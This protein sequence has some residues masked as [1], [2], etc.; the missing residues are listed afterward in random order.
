MAGGFW[1]HWSS[2]AEI[3]LTGN[4]DFHFKVSANGSSWKESIIIDKDTGYVGVGTAPSQPL[5]IR[6]DASSTHYVKVESAQAQNAGFQFVCPATTWY[7]YNQNSTKQWRFYNGGTR[8]AI[9]HTGQIGI[10]TTTLTEKVNVAGN[11]APSSSGSYSLGTAAKLWSDVYATNGTINTSDA[12]LK[13]DIKSSDLGLN[14]ILGLKPIRYKWSKQEETIKQE[15]SDEDGV[16]KEVI[17]SKNKGRRTHY[18]LLAQDVKQTLQDC[19][20]EDF[21]G[22]TLADKDAPDSAQGLRY[23]ELIAPLIKA[24]QELNAKVKTLKS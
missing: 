8:L 4:D 16:Y 2:R 7:A 14:F 9:A 18:G 12:R 22:W 13:T 6:K 19:G 5:T 1:R 11:I 24:V 20:C 15:T 21:A 3:G 10:G 17:L 23:T